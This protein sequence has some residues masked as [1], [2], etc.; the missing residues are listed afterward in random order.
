MKRKILILIVILVVGF[1][2][3]KERTFNN[4]LGRHILTEYTVDG[5]DSLQSYQ[6]SLG[7]EFYFFYDDLYDQYVAHI[8]GYSEVYDEK[9]VIWNWH[10]HDNFKHLE[11][12]EDYSITIG[13]GPI[14][15]DKTPTWD[16]LKLTNKE[17]KLSTFYNNKE[18]VL[19]LNNK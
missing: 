13:I 2:C 4:I 1:G 10:L 12:Y 9:L 18:Y 7:T 6:D 14:G 15:R 11:V 5:V 19:C 8:L 17:M 16:I 3:K